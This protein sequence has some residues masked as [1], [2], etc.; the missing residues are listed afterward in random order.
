MEPLSSQA[1]FRWNLAAFII[2]A[3]LTIA[4]I[5]AL[6]HAPP[7]WASNWPHWNWQDWTSFSSDLFFP[8]MALLSFADL[9]KHKR[10]QG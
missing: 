8:M 6:L 1:R 9:R 7:I 4:D 10:S 3:F 5:F 2:F